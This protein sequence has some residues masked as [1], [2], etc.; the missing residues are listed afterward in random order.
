MFFIKKEFKKIRNS[1][2]SWNI[3][4][5]INYVRITQCQSILH[6]W[7]GISTRTGYS[8]E[9]RLKFEQLQKNWPENSN[10]LLLRSLGKFHLTISYSH[11]VLLVGKNSLSICIVLLKKQISKCLILCEDYLKQR[12]NKIFIGLSIIELNDDLLVEFFVL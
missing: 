3:N 1:W 7:V 2:G 10:N 12:N 9:L 11:Q 8:F 4:E 5:K 6:K